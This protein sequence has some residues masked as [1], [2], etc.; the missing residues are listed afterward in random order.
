MNTIIFDLNCVVIDCNSEYFFL[1]K[2]RGDRVDNY[3]DEVTG[4]LEGIYLSNHTKLKKELS[5]LK[6][7][8]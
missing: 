2:F 4:K 7:E 3:E 5:K 8:I 6:I 1:K